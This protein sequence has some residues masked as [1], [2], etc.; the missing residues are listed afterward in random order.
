VDLRLSSDRSWLL[1]MV[2]DTSRYP[3]ERVGAAGDEQHGRGLL[4]VDAISMIW[5]WEALNDS[6]G[7]VIRAL[8]E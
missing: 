8:I 1:I 6:S 3:P 2:Q 7:E 4:I 5:V